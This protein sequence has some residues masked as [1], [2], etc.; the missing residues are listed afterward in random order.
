LRS[1]LALTNA[2]GS[3]SIRSM[4]DIIPTLSLVHGDGKLSDQIAGEFARCILKGEL[5]AGTKLPTE[6][7][8]GTLLG[9]SRTVVRDAM[10][11][12]SV[13]GLV[14]V[15]HGHGM[16]VA[17]TSEGAFTD[18]FIV[19]LLRSNLTVAEVLEGRQVIELG[20]CPLAA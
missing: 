3:A 2:R 7:E 12:L 6:S 15:R 8:L 17:S 13:R 19:L 20:I 1:H 10:R 16:E 4:Y 11:T 18:A 14:Q 9:V 5:P